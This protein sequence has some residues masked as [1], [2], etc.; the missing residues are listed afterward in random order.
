MEGS[1]G[2]CVPAPTR[3]F[4]LPWEAT[5]GQLAVMTMTDQETDTLRRMSPAQKLA[6]MH[7]LIRQ[8]FELKAATVRARWPELSE[9]EVQERTW[10]QVAGDDS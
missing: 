6:V 1:P 4:T 3:D 8:A 5:P 7:A 10:R 9:H 2:R